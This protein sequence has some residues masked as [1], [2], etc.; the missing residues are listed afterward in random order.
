MN[1]TEEAEEMQLRAGALSQIRRRFEIPVS[2]KPLLYHTCA[3]TL[4][5]IDRADRIAEAAELDSRE[6]MLVRLAAAF[7]DVHIEWTFEED[8]DGY[9][10]RTSCAGLNEVKSAAEA[11]SLLRASSLGFTPRELAMVAHA[12]I[13]TTPEWND[14]FNTVVQ[15]LV[16]ERPH[17][18]T[19]CV[20]MADLGEAGM[21]PESFIPNSYR[22]F[23]ELHDGLFN[24]VNKNRVMAKVEHDT[25]TKWFEGQVR[26][27]DS[28]RVQTARELSWFSGEH[29]LVLQE[30]FSGFSMVDGMVR[31]EL[32]ILRSC[33]HLHAAERMLAHLGLVPA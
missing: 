23:A 20:A 7:H 30:L 10:M 14:L 6:R 16:G 26:F 13:A 31:E 29:Y 8:R 32:T 11:V 15:P 18:V 17:P 28:R 4:A 22:L 21:D 3:H 24:C 27:V 9:G 1:I 19:A 33:S 25:L 12:I 5:V 2:G